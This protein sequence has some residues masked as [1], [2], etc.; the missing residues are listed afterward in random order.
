M[1]VPFELTLLTDATNYQKWMFNEVKPFL[2]TRILELG[3]GLGNMSTWLPHEKG[4]RLLTEAD[5]ELFDYLENKFKNTPN[6]IVKKIDLEQPF[7]TQVTEY[8]VDTIVSF[9]V[10]EHIDDHFAAFKEQI[11]VLKR[12]KATGSKRLV[13][14]MPAH[15][16]A[17]G[18]YDR[19]FKHYRRYEAQD[20]KKI[21]NQIDPDLKVKTFYFNLVSLLAW[22]YNGRIKKET[23]FKASQVKF[24][25]KLVPILAPIDSFL[26]KVL[27]VPF[28]QSVICVVQI[29]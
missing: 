21:F 6:T 14:L 1:N 16:F 2:G 17:F 3:A 4:L 12:S 26:H 24:F 20:L 18:S 7:S 28:G 23:T 27:R 5:N 8:N 22:I 19:V 29:Q 9:N 11:E 15:A 10:M 13:A 25:E